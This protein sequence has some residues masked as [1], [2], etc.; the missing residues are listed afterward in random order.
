MEIWKR[1]VL[2]CEME[3]NIKMLRVSHLCKWSFYLVY[4]VLYSLKGYMCKKGIYVLC[5]F[6]NML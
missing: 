5:T 6:D 2:W 3:V 4:E 1:G